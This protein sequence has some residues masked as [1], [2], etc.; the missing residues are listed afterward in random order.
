MKEGVEHGVRQRLSAKT[1]QHLRMREEVDGAANPQRGMPLSTKAR[2]F[3]LV[4]QR[5]RDLRKRISDRRGLAVVERVGCRTDDEPFKVL[6]RCVAEADDLDGA[7]GCKGVE[8]IGILAVSLA[9]PLQFLGHNV[10]D[11]DPIG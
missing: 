6:K 7:A 11:N 5:Y 3:A 10:D 2:R 4:N 9:S 8:L 1:L